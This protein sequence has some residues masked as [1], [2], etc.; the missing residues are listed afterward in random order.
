M[1]KFN[2][3]DQCFPTFFWLA[4]PLPS[5]EDIWWH[6]SCFNGYKDQ[7]IVTMATPLS[8]AH[9]TPVGNRVTRWFGQKVAANFVKIALFVA[10]FLFFIFSSLK[11]ALFVAQ[12]VKV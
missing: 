4:T 11:V 2:N 1:R 6:P 8:P 12:S 3:Q 10:I 7:G 5:D 9:G